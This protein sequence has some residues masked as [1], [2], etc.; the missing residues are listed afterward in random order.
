MHISVSRSLIAF[1]FLISTANA[2][3]TDDRILKPNAMVEY[4]KVPGEV[5]S[6]GEI[7][8]NGDVYG[9]LRSNNF[10]YDFDAAD[11]PT[12]QDHDKFSVG[13]NLTYKTAFF[14][15]FGA[16]AGFYGAVALG[17]DNVEGITNYT[18]TA[19]DLFR[20][21]ADGTE[22]NIGVFAIGY[23]EYKTQHNDLM[24]GRQIVDSI[25]LSSN[26]A[27]MIPNTF[28]G[29][30]LENSNIPDTKLR[31]GY[32]MSQKLRDHQNFHSIIAYAKRDEND[33]GSSN[34]GLTPFLISKYGA[35]VNPEMVLISAE[36]KSIRNLKLTGEYIDINGFF[37]TIIA[38]A[39]YMIPLNNGW[40][41]T[42]GFRYLEQDD[43][44]AGII[45]GA[46]ISGKFKDNYSSTNHLNYTEPN[47]VDGHLWAAR[48]VLD[49][50]PFTLMGGYSTVADKGDIIAPWRGFP[51]G[52]Y[53]RAMAQTNWL[54]NTDSWMVA[55]TYDF[56]KGQRIPGLLCSASFSHINIDDSKTA[57]ASI[58]STDRN[59]IYF[60]AIQT[61]KSLPN[62]EFKFRFANVD[63]ITNLNTGVNDSYSEYRFEI[64]YLF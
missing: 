25:L 50:G 34:Q 38:E 6:F 36:N 16:T 56:D 51:T 1:S 15:G 28:Q 49:K 62:S 53:T 32:L 61:L 12:A 18:K 30:V 17:A 11:T 19:K 58:A 60:D 44:G 43:D 48:I 42:P 4:T 46:A 35:D 20:T 52:G 45:G 26:D 5:D 63:A 54:A 64:N 59:I 10:W 9:R 37:S 31:I 2:L 47:S 55:T 33:D 22:A 3:T 27:K 40:K 23:G 29:A 21:R 7:F 24:I 14:H 8:T 39:N 41:M 13:G 57:A